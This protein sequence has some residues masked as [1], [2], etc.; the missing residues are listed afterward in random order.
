MFG[1]TT[2]YFIKLIFSYLDEERKLVIIKYSKKFQDIA[3]IS[4]VN[5]KFFSGRNIIFEKDGIAKE[6]GY[7]GDVLIYE[8]GYLNGKRN[9]KGTTYNYFC[10]TEEEFKYVGEY[11]NGKRNGKGKEYYYDEIL[12]FEGEYLNGKRNGKGKEYNHEGI[13]VF[14]GEYLN[15]VINGK[16]KEYNKK[17]KLLYEGEY[18]N[19]VRNGKGKEY[20][21]G[22]LLY[23]GD[24][25]IGQRVGSE[26]L[27]EYA[28]YDYLIFYHFSS[29]YWPLNSTICL[30]SSETGW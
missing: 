18:L 7:N 27:K 5:Y 1:N 13:L 20:K 29:I 14:E 11:L 17:G 30:R 24:Y 2:E 25:L 28:E 6:Y 10:S 23:V 16:G 19:G 8:G 9:G 22:K 15:G 21:N 12:L 3:D 26:K 4:L